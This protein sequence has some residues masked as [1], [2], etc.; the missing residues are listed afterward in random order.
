MGAI[1]F[2]VFGVLEYWSDGVMTQRPVGFTTLQYSITPT[3][4]FLKLSNFLNYLFIGYS[5]DNL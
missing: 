4:L 5:S 2:S 3:E 1:N